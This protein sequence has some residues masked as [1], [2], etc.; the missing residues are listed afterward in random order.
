MSLRDSKSQDGSTTIIRRVVE[1]SVRPQIDGENSLSTNKI[2]TTIAR[3]HQDEQREMQELNNKFSAYLDRVHYLE[4]QN[5]FLNKELDFLRKNWAGETGKIQVEFD[6]KIRELRRSIDDSIRNQALQELQLK[7]HE[8]EIF[9]IEQQINSLNPDHDRERLAFV[10]N[11]LDQSIVELEQIRVEFDQRLKDLSRQRQSMEFSLSDLNNLKNELD[12]RQIERILLESEIQTLREHAAFEEATFKVQ[13]DEFEALE[14]TPIDVSGFYRNELA[15]AISEI[16]SDFEILSRG[17][18]T[19]LEEFYRIKTEEVQKKIEEDEKKRRQISKENILESKENSVLR[20][21]IK[22]TSDEIQHLKNENI[23]LQNY[24]DSLLKDF[25]QIQSEREKE[26]FLLEKNYSELNEKINEKENL[27]GTILENNVSLQFEISTYRHLLEVEENHLIRTEKREIL[28]NFPLSNNNE[29][30]KQNATKKMTVS[31]TARGPISID[32]VDLE[33]DSIVLIN[34]KFS[35]NE[36]N[37]QNWSLRRE[38]DKNEE[39]QFVFPDSFSLRPRESVR[40]LSKNSPVTSRLS[41]NVLLAENLRTWGQGQKM[42]TRLVD[43]NNEEKAI[44]TQ[45]F[46]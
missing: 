15:R 8:Y 25:E 14:S 13:L 16:R 28:P 11:Q 39:I 9:Q 46:Q 38:N 10:K 18:S 6:P 34:E 36:Q 1:R 37:L 2:L 5:K 17:R 40:I 35:G 33:T 43:N 26:N 4:N 21:S 29:N 3:Q 19:E 23:D 7:R 44:V 32:S 31:K 41:S 42:V 12:S 22:E 20:S 27:I 30:E 24:F 45:Q